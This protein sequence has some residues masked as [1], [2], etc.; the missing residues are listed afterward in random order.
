MLAGVGVGL[1]YPPPIQVLMGWF[2]DKKGVAM[3]TLVAGFGGG[4]LAFVSAWNALTRHFCRSPT[5]IGGVDEVT[6]TT[7]DGVLFA[8]V[9][10]HGAGGAG[11]E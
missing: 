5:F 1:C 4:A 9:G 7:R 11:E 8:D 6:T 2:P 10:A 3:G